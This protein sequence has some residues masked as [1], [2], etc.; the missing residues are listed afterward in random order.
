MC[1]KCVVRLQGV[2]TE[3]IDE[4]IVDKK[5]ITFRDLGAIPSHSTIQTMKFEG[6]K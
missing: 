2:D 3:R 4:L 1:I 6:W 5:T